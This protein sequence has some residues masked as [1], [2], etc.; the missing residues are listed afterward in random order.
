M[1]G[2]MGYKEGSK[3][4]EDIT[5]TPDLWR[6]SIRYGW[7]YDLDVELVNNYYDEDAI[8]DDENAHELVHMDNEESK[9]DDESECDESTNE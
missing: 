5:H 6:R 1:P 9:S 4:S 2:V 8:I 3:E 7:R